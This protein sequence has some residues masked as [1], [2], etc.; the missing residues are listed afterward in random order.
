MAGLEAPAAALPVEAA[1]SPPLER[2]GSSSGGVER[3][4]EAVKGGGAAEEAGMRVGDQFIEVNGTRVESSQAVRQLLNP[5]ETN[6]I[7][8]LRAVAESSLAELQALLDAAR[9]EVARALL[10]PAPCAPLITLSHLGAL[11]SSSPP[12]RFRFHNVLLPNAHLLHNFLPLPIPHGSHCAIATDR[13]TAAERLAEESGA[14]AAAA[15]A[16]EAAALARAVQAEAEAARL[17]EARGGDSLAAGKAAQLEAQLVELRAELASERARAA[18]AE[19]RAT[20]SARLLTSA[21][22]TNAEATALRAQL[23]HA[24]AERDRF[25]AIAREL[26]RQRDEAREACARSSL[27]SEASS[28]A[29]QRSASLGAMVLGPVQGGGGQ[30]S[31]AACACRDSLQSSVESSTACSTPTGNRP[32]MGGLVGEKGTRSP[33]MAAAGGLEA[34]ETPPRSALVPAAAGRM[35]GAMPGAVPAGVAVYDSNLAEGALPLVRN[36]SAP[37]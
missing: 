4:L 11:L 31:E 13:R 8:V 37:S 12:S 3:R 18:A 36:L 30:A 7:S 32:L 5:R 1:P 26:K 27:P 25:R 10:S 21:A 34:C 15:A 17:R 24:E 28:A 14:A 35:P 22:V 9:V 2:H 29:P 19:E 20:E 16:A 33:V 6:T 23:S